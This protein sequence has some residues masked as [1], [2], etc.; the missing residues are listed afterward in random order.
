V[1]AIE[2]STTLF[3]EIRG[4]RF[5]DFVGGVEKVTALLNRNGLGRLGLHLGSP[6]Q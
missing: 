6:R 5:D 4:H 1:L 2:L 3:N